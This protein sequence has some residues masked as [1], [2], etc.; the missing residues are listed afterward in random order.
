MHVHIAVRVLTDGL[1]SQNW[2]WRSNPPG[3][4]KQQLPDALKLQEAAP[5]VPHPLEIR[6]N[7]SFGLVRGVAIAEATSVVKARAVNI[8]K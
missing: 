3:A 1:V 7:R 8:L 5:L 6:L 4:S 2:V